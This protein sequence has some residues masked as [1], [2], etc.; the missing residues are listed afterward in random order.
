MCCK[1]QGM[2]SNIFILISIFCFKM[3]PVCDIFSSSLRST[4]DFVSF[5]FVVHRAVLCRIVKIRRKTL[6]RKTSFKTKL[7]F[8]FNFQWKG[9]KLS[10]VY[11]LFV[12][13]I[14]LISIY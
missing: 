14:F 11:F 9:R 2:S 13:I 10:F 8:L 7:I 5:M 4:L 6:R 3:E 1:S 12:W